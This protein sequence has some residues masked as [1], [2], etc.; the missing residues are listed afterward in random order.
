MSR[1]KCPL[2]CGKYI[3]LIKRIIPVVILAGFGWLVVSVITSG[4]DTESLEPA[5]VKAPDVVKYRPVSPGG[6]KIAHQDKKVFDLLDAK[7]SQN[8]SKFVLAES[9]KEEKKISKKIAEKRPVKKVIK[10]IKKEEVS[11][12]VVVLKNVTGWAVQLGSFRRTADAERA[13]KIYQGKVGDILQGLNSYVKEVDL[14]EKGVVFRVY[15]AG[16]KDKDHAKQ[17]CLQLK[18]KKQGCLKAKL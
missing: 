9:K 17:I 1:L 2:R 12:S 15:F 4:V 8:D 13:V 18:A 3:V 10:S 11:K 16:L 5:T 14:G 7:T 6:M